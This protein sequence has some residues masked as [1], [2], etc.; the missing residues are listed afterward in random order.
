MQNDVARTPHGPTDEVDELVA[1]WG[2]ERPDLNTA[3][4]QL[5][6]RITRLAQ[7][8]D[9]ARSE[10]FAAQ[11]LQV[12]EFDVLAALRRAGEPY[13]LSPGQLITQTH[14]TSGTMTNR[15]DRLVS[16]GLVVRQ[17]NPLDG[18]G[19]LVELTDEGR[20]KA[21][22]AL[23]DLVASEDRMAAVLSPAQSASLAKILRMLLLAQENG[24]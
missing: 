19:V 3:P 2:R 9:T 21:D 18:R 11:E 5:W 8:L 12:W 1:A 6:S 13:R 4:M 20:A 24:D 15:V 22:A 23:A 16:R 17:A 10:A 14:V 7:L